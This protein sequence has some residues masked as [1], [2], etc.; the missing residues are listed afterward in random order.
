MTSL[1]AGG[2]ANMERRIRRTTHDLE[3][4][5]AESIQ[6]AFKAK[7]VDKRPTL[8]ADDLLLINDAANFF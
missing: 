3:A 2:S 4:P 5:W 6:T 1:A 8:C 7:S